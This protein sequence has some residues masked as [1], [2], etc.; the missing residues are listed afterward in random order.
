[1]NEI[2]SYFKRI[3]SFSFNA[4]LYLLAS[5]IGAL[6]YSVY[7]VLGNIYIMKAGLNESFLGTMI[8]IGSISSV[9]FALPA[10]AL[11]DRIGRRKTM[12]IAGT[13]GAISNIV[14]VLFPVAPVILVCTVVGGASGAMM[15]VTYAPFLT[16]N[17]TGTERTHLFSIAFA[18]NTISGIGGSFIGG[19]MPIIW[20]RVLSV[21][22]DTLL[23]YRAT[24]LTTLLIFSISII[25]FIYISERKIERV[26]IPIKFSF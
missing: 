22:P 1:M 24:L 18:T 23:A 8:S 19:T 11:S 3:K 2:Y 25:P 9:L 7:S 4:R 20:G 6:Y 15:M 14:M 21:A 26:A 17:S 12:L 13:L 10:G 5:F 16:E